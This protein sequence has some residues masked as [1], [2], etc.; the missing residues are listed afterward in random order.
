MPPEVSTNIPS[1]IVPGNEL[2]GS[3]TVKDDLDV[4]KTALVEITGPGNYKKTMTLNGT[5]GTFSIA[6]FSFPNTGDFN[7]KITVTD[8][9]GNKSETTGYVACLEP[10]PTPPTS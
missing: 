3:F 8:G 6:G 10:A 1:F 5:R 7:I 9:N 2:K 4:I